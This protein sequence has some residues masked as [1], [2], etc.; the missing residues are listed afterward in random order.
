MVVI[1]VLATIAPFTICIH[2]IAHNLI[3]LLI[4]PTYRRAIIDALSVWKWASKL[5]P[6]KDNET[7]NPIFTSSK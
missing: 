2:P 1:S 3:L 6:K 7:C 5:P 4:I